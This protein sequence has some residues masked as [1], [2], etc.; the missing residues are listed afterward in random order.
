MEIQRTFNEQ[1]HSLVLKPESRNS[2]AH[3]TLI[4]DAATG[5]QLTQMGGPLD[6]GKWPNALHITRRADAIGVT[7]VIIQNTSPPHIS[8]HLLDIPMALPNF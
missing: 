3:A 2:G 7:T 5:N 1:Q 4:R 6:V 8:A